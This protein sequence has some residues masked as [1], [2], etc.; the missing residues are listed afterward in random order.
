MESALA[1]LRGKAKTDKKRKSSADNLNNYRKKRKEAQQC[2]I[3]SELTQD[4]SE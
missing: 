2:A 3:R 4:T 1:A